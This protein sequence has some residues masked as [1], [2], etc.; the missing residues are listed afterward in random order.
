[1]HQFHV[2]ELTGSHHG[3]CNHCQQYRQTPVQE[4]VLV[5]FISHIPEPLTCFP[6]TRT[7][8]LNLFANQDNQQGSLPSVRSVVI[9][10]IALA[11]A[12]EPVPHPHRYTGI[13]QGL[14]IILR[15]EM[16]QTVLNCICPEP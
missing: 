8:K 4:A 2:I 10:T 14:R 9:R 15:N 1:M 3:E 7:V 13:G 6:F 11:Q 16:K 12:D 5:E